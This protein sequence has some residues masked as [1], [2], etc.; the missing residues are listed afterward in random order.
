MK[1]LNKLKFNTLQ[2][3]HGLD[4]AV[5]YNKIAG[6]YDSQ[7]VNLL[8]ILDEEL[9]KTIT[10]NIE[11][12]GK[13]IA[14]IGCGTGRHWPYLFSKKPAE[15]FGFDVSEKMLDVLRSKY[16]SANVYMQ[17]SN[18]LPQLANESCNVVISTLT[19]GYIKNIEAAFR[20]WSRILKAGGDFIFTDYHPTLL[21][22]GGNRNFVI[23]GKSSSAKNYIHTIERIAK[24]TATLGLQTVHYQEKTIDESV[25]SYYTKQDAAHIY[26]RFKGTPLIYGWHLKKSDAAL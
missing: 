18:E 17:K 14:D 21:E 9:F 16:F 6:F 1:L 7:P 8:H 26:N 23:N 5:F 20:E 24:I 10:D 25:E 13:N 3:N 15:L 4:A 22:K 19:I 11:I 12:T 2:N